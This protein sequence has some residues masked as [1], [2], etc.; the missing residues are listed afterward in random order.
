MG[1]TYLVRDIDPMLWRSVKASAAKEGLTIRA[2][3]LRFLTEY[4]DRGA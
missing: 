4:A 2:V 1:S 3:I